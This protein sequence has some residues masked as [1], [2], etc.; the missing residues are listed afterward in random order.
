MKTDF[1]VV[2]DYGTGGLW[3]VIRARS[4]DEIRRKFS[5]IKVV[6][7]RPFSMTDDEYR[8]IASSNLH[9]ID[10]EPRGWLATLRKNSS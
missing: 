9:D 8:E 5:E 2:Y 10:D 1:L 7:D 3:A 6:D 4:K